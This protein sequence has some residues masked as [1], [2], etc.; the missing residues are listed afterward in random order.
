MINNVVSRSNLEDSAIESLLEE[1][2]S[3]DQESNR[4][5]HKLY[6]NFTCDEMFEELNASFS[7][8][9]TQLENNYFDPKTI[10]KTSVS[11]LPTLDPIQSF[12]TLSETH[13]VLISSSKVRN[14]E[15][16]VI[17]LLKQ[18]KE[19]FNY[20]MDDVSAMSFILTHDLIS[21]VDN[22]IL[23]GEFHMC[24]DCVTKVIMILRHAFI[25]VYWAID[26]S[27]AG[28]LE[29]ELSSK[30]VSFVDVMS[31]MV[32]TNWA[33]QLVMADLAIAGQLDKAASSLLNRRIPL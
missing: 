20:S 2:V 3:L 18:H 21:L 25:S 14:Q 26:V 4:E 24:V 17:N 27:D 9:E 29:N 10:V 23:M 1:D 5:L 8:H 16:Q 28:D 19:T 30:Q 32:A 7:N 15:F 22:I 12:S 11:E 31:L 33:N 13:D 6:K